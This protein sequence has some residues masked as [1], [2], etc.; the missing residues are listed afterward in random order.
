MLSQENAHRSHLTIP[1]SITELRYPS[2][3]KNK[4]GPFIQCQI[5]RWIFLVF[6]DFCFHTS[7]SSFFSLLIVS[8]NNSSIRISLSFIGT[9]FWNAI[10]KPSILL[11]LCLFASCSSC[12]LPGISS[13]DWSSPTASAS[14][15]V[16]STLISGWISE[17]KRFI[18]TY[19]VWFSEAISSSNCSTSDWV[20]ALSNGPRSVVCRKQL[21][22]VV[23]FT[24]FSWL[25]VIIHGSQL[26]DGVNVRCIESYIV[27]SFL[28]LAFCVCNACQ[29]KL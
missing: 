23:G 9:W 25:Q 8:L 12:S 28:I 24:F 15:L 27:E 17:N 29:A 5:F 18:P 21:L 3:S 11:C 10:S 16:S 7:M 6:I 1:A 4:L 13:P 19:K 14:A 20:L 26:I 2:Y 22:I